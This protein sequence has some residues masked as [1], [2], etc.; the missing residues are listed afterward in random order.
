MGFPTSIIHTYSAVLNHKEK[1]EEEDW[2][3]KEIDKK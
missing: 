2:T 1:E 3:A